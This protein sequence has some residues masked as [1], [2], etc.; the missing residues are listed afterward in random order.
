MDSQNSGTFQT[1]EF[2]ASS[3]RFWYVCLG[4]GMWFKGSEGLSWWATITDGKYAL[5]TRDQKGEKQN[6]IIPKTPFSY[7][8]EEIPVSFPCPY[9]LW[10]FF[11]PSCSFSPESG[12]QLYGHSYSS[13]FSLAL[14]VLARFYDFSICDPLVPDQT[15]LS[16]YPTLWCFCL[17][18]HSYLKSHFYI[19]CNI[20]V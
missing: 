3:L 9:F 1:S 19:K 16:L 7:E 20:K 5:G 15:S 12:V 13:S 10:I 18:A 14:T 6:Q 17:G 2:S 8:V 11:S 4:G